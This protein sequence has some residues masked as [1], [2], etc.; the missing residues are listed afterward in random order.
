MCA[1]LGRT[2]LADDVDHI[3]PHKGDL[4]LFYDINNL[5]GL[6]RFHHQSTKARIER[7][8]EFGC[9]KDGVPLDPKHH[10]NA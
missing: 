4:V 1:D 10:W 7:S 9:D 6:C 5:Q 2:E 3:V 8:G